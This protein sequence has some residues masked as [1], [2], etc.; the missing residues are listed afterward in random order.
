VEPPEFEPRAFSPPLASFDGAPFTNQWPPDT[1]GDVGPEHYIQ[2]VNARS[3]GGGSAQMRIYR[4][5]G[6]LLAGPVE[7]GSVWAAAGGSPTSECATQGYGDP[8]ALYDPLADRWL[9]SEMTDPLDTDATDS[10]C[11]YV[12]RTADPVA[13]GWYAY[14]FAVSSGVTIKV[15]YPKYAVWPDAYYVSNVNTMPNALERSQMLLGLPAARQEIPVVS[16]VPV[17]PSDLDGTNP[18][19]AGSPCFF[20]GHRDDEPYPPPPPATV[21]FPPEVD[22]PRDRNPPGVLV[23][24]VV[25]AAATSGSPRLLARFSAGVAQPRD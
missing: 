13:G 1:V 10:M 3:G 18:P 22:T 9:V 24:M 6:L 25:Q 17:L 12:S 8:I 4:K 23:L 14:D 5:D 21:V 20:V 2:L 7:L 16:I 19:P 11:V 15:D